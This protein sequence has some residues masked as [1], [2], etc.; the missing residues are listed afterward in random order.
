MQKTLLFFII[1]IVVMVG[2]V[3]NTSASEVDEPIWRSTDNCLVANSSEENPS[4]SIKMTAMNFGDITYDPSTEVTV[5]SS[6][7]NAPAY[8]FS[9]VD[10]NVD[11]GQYIVIASYA[12][13]DTVRTQDITGLPL[14]YGYQLIDNTSFVEYM[15]QEKT[16][17]DGE[18]GTWDIVY[19]IYPV[20]TASLTQVRLFMM[21]AGQTGSEYDGSEG[22]FVGSGVYIVNSQEEGEA[23]IQQYEED[24]SHVGE[25]VNEDSENNTDE[26]TGELN[27][28]KQPWEN[29]MN[30]L[31]N[32]SSADN[33]NCWAEGEQ[34]F[35]GKASYNEKNNVTTI[36]N[37]VNSPAHS[38]IDVNVNAE[39]GQYFLMVGFTQAQTVRENGDST[40]LPYFYGDQTDGSGNSINYMQSQTV[41]TSEES[42]WG[43]NYGLFPVTE[44]VQKVRLFMMQSLQEGSEYDGSEAYFKQPG[45]FIVQ[46]PEEANE[47]VASYEKATHAQM[48][49][50]IKQKKVAKKAIR[51]QW[52]EQINAEQ[53]IVKL[54]R[55]IDGERKVLQTLK[56]EDNN[57]VKIKN[58]KP[59][60]KYRVTVRAVVNGEKSN[61]ARKSIRTAEDK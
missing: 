47:I 60:T 6:F 58:L 41:L 19:G 26:N 40:G 7:P 31:N 10:V 30:C 14:I 9:D 34:Q 13:T 49:K 51:I 52:A 38:L 28:P 59:G 20:A 46:S 35:F 36:A 24:A 27:L 21:Q 37:E 42:E 22:K 44:G 61:W 11:E 32:T 4:C 8:N 50:R 18:E 43:M 2:S 12:Y 29:A 55:K 54:K 15:Q 45:L 33:E 5:L 39:P 57:S 25:V 23:I 53:Y 16:L 3:Q 56:V 1:M 48:I 17:F